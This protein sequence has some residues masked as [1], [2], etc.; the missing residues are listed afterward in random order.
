MTKPQH[1]PL[2]GLVVAQFF[3]AYNDNAFK[4]FVALLSIRAVR[5]ATGGEGPAFEAASQSRTTLAFVVFTLPLVL[6][7]L[8]AGFLADR[9]SKRSVILGM[10]G[11]EIVLMAA[12]ATALF[13][14]PTGVALPL[15]LL[16]MM[17]VQTAFFSPA[18]YGILPEI[19]PHDRLSAGNGLLEMWTFIAIIAGTATGG[20]LLD[21]TGRSAWIA[22][23]VLTSLAVVG[24][25]AARTIPRVPPARSEGGFVVTLRGAWSSI[26]ADRVLWMAVI[27]ST[28]FWGVT[29]LLGQ[30][31]LVYIKTVLGASDS[32]SGIPLALFGLGVGAGTV[33]AGKLSASKVEYGLLPLGSV[34]LALFTILL[35][36]IA[37]GFGGTLV[38]MACLGITSGLL[39]VPLN[40]ILQWRSP[41]DRRAALLQCGQP[42]A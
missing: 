42:D 31:V 36:G 39:V 10:K 37:P 6:V 34:G 3:G 23:A 18:K 22:G 17:G 29:S 27:G 9:V 19:L 32:R 5:A 16:G 21:A 28:Y 1:H 15:I 40:A 25:L 4:L 35:G 8:P 13:M 12:G 41:A 24:F 11:M 30:D 7:S 26:R 2:R 33:L 20:P 38:L 14:N